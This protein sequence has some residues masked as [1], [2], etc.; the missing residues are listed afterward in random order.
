MPDRQP[1][2]ACV[3]GARPNFVKIA[4]ILRAIARRGD[5][6]ARL[7]HSGQHY[8]VAMN[9]VFFEEL[10]IP[11]PDIDLEVGSG[12]HSEQLARV[13]LAIEP[14]FA[15]E[16]P[17][18]VLV[19][20]DVNT[21]LAATLVASRLGIPVAHVEAGLRSRDRT[22][23]EEVNR[24]LTDAISDLLFTT[25]R[26][27]IENLTREG[28]DPARVTFVG[29]VMIDTLFACLERAVPVE[30]TLAEAG[31][32]EAFRARVAR[33]GLG[34]VTLHR[35]SN[36]DEPEKLARVLDALGT[37]SET[38]PL[39]F[40]Q[41]P[42]TKAVIERA[43][44]DSR[45]RRDGILACRPLSYLAIVGAMRAAKLVVTDS[46]GIQ[47]ETTALGVP[48]LTLRDNTERP[49]TIAEG[50]N[51]LIGS[52]PA[53]LAPAVAEALADGDRGGHTPELW[54]GRAAERIAERIAAFLAGRQGVT[55]ASA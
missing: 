46:G 17:D 53:A 14:V 47:E 50:T 34:L 23:P 2:I 10:A 1:T 15:R 55:A 41:H 9:T 18:L 4:P 3:V 31:A 42:R 44:L 38:L 54:D 24:I 7:I 49:I 20:G 27:A 48:C 16:R 39:L 45:L 51:R 5:L 26:G 11:K 28:I 22:M 6:T 36:V 43:G 37:V 32:D 19:V 25:E 33:D 52:D 29:N 13:M 35:P 21:T 8:D 30:R 12:T 40:P